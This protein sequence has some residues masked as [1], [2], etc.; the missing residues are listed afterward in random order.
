MLE[1][2]GWQRRGRATHG[3]FLY[4]QF[5]GEPFPRTTVIPDKADDLPEGTLGA[6][7]SVKQ[8]GLG[9]AGLKALMEKHGPP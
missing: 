8:T 4:M 3:V 5:P 9:R 2:D 1:M 6:I 7:L